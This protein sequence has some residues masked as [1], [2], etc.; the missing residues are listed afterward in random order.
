MP[1]VCKEY[2]NSMLKLC[3]AYFDITSTFAFLD[4]LDLY[5]NPLFKFFSVG[6]DT[7]ATVGLACNLLKLF[8]S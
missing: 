8:K 2:A 1:I 3:I 7:H 5:G 6:D 4:D